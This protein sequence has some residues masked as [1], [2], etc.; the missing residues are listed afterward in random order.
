MDLHIRKA[1]SEDLPNILQLYRQPSVD[2]G[3]VLSPDEAL[4][5]FNRMKEYP[6]YAVYIAEMDGGIVGTFALAIMNNLA[7]KG[8]PSGLI[9]DVVV[10][11]RFQGQ[12]I[13]TAMMRQAIRICREKGCY[14]A[15]LS[16]N[17][18]RENAHRFYE[19]IGFKIHG[20]SFLI[21]CN[22]EE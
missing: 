20:F 14:K 3:D 11:E 21:D 2:N 1:L 10:T 5:I 13:G 15:M 4:R 22:Q 17:I 7:H 19:S 16:S 6:D 9:E 8:M 18:K 12:G